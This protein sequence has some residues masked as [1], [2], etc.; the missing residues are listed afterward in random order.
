MGGILKPGENCMG[1][2]NVGGAA[3]FI[4]GRDYYRAFHHA[5]RR[6]ERYILMAGW[7]FDSRVRLLRGADAGKEGE[8]PLLP[9]L[10]GLCEAN[11]GLTI[12]ILAWDYSMVFS[13]E[14]EWFQKV[15]FDWQ[16][17]KRI[18]FRFDASH[19]V[20]A[21][22]HQKFVVVDGAAAFAGGMDICSERWDDR[23]HMPHNPERKEPGFE[24]YGPYHDAQAYVTGEAASEL[25]E[26]FR[27]RWLDSGGEDIKIS[28]PGGRAAK[29]K[30]TLPIAAKRVAISRT[31]P[32]RLMPLEMEPV[33][34]IMRLFQDAIAS[35][36]RLIYMENQYFTSEAVYRALLGRMSRPGAPRLQVAVVLPKSVHGFI[37]ELS[38]AKAQMRLFESLSDTAERHGHSLGI[39][40]T[41]PPGDEGETV[42]TYIHSKVLI[43]DDAFISIGSANCTNRSMGLDS[44]LNLSFEAGPEEMRLTDSIRRV[45][46]SLLAEH[47]GLGHGDRRRRLKE[48]DGLA[49]YLDGLV[50]GKGTRLRRHTRE[51]FFWG[52][53]WLKEMAAGELTFDPDRP[54]AEEELFE[55]MSRDEKGL[56][57]RGIRMLN[58][59]MF[60]RGR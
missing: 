51:S 20:G 13:L 31:A 26:I 10:D 9:F 34:E 42:P 35:A 11:P 44:E 50:A 14:R 18:H 30:P 19:P 22:H 33:Q 48:I 8:A 38:F 58:D 54:V 21:S 39:Y 56:F 41:G 45:R 52:S 55:I 2:Y 16:S 37:E 5:A 23:R 3:V 46:V 4:D 27:K 47:A 36:E 24:S 15:R 59:W 60:G 28:Y 43:V 29:L 49:G 40:Y 7:Q 25:A 6:A 57:A 1:I 53:D 12:Y 32:R 17:C